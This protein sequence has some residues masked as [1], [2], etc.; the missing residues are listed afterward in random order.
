MRRVLLALLCFCALATPASA[1]GVD[2]TC[3]LALTRFDAATINI[4][5]PDDSANYWVGAYQAVPGTRLRITGR[6]PHARYMSFNVYD[7]L[8]RPLDAIADVEIR[9]DA[10]STNPFAPGA[11]RTAAKRDYTVVVDLGPKP[12]TPAPNTIYTGTGQ[13]GVPNVNG[14]LIYRIYIPDRLRNE[15]GDTAIP[16]VQI[17]PLTSTG[18]LAPSVCGSFSKPS[19]TGVNEALANANAIPGLDAVTPSPGRNPPRWR[20]F[21]NLVAG[22]LYG[23]TDSE[24]TD[25][26]Y[27]ALRQLDLDTAGGTGGFLSNIHNAYV[28][29]TVNRQFGQVL[30]TRFK[31]PT[32]PDTRPGPARMPG[33]QVRYW[34][35]CQNEPLTQRYTA[36]LN[37]DRGV[38]GADG[39]STFVISAP[40]QRPANATRECGVNWLPW[41]FTS[42]GLVILRHML[43]EASFGASIQKAKVDHEADAMGDGLPRSQ[44]YAGPAAYEQRGCAGV[45]LPAARSCKSRRA[46]TI[47]LPRNAV[48]ARV[49]VNGKLVRTL[50]GRRL[51]ARVDLRGLPR[52]RV[53]VKISARLRSGRVVQVTRT[54]HPCAKAR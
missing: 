34:S 2:E 18:P 40:N 10:G 29:A 27:Q 35:L 36:C 26:A 9:P 20:R 46:F 45:L 51:R 39:F 11:D 24:R 31:A 22:L 28:S 1:Q 54:Y 32:F 25:P 30:V 48:S 12:A 8:Q 42:R 52:T 33:G 23:I 44:Y 6:F 5:F 41:G 19:I 7:Q 43:P 15:F 14:T 38:V 3:L 53:R 37:D 17:E 50:R 13:N 21:T 4:A 47:H 16:T 49:R